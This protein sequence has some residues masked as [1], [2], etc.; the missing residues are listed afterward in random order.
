[1]NKEKEMYMIIESLS[2]RIESVTARDVCSE[3]RKEYHI[4]MMRLEATRL[5]ELLG[6][7]EIEGDNDGLLGVARENFKK[8]E[9]LIASQGLI[10]TLQLL[11]STKKK[12][13]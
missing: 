6:V 9:R 8:V 12:G 11:Q 2:D 3:D 13:K 10:K 7:E 4:S 5:L 1:M